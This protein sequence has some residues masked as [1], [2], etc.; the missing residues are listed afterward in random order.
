MSELG[1]GTVILVVCGFLVSFIG[2]FLLGTQVDWK[3]KEDR[4]RG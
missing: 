4:S 3:K 2:G 1:I